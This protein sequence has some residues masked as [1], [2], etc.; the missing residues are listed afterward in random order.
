MLSVTGCTYLIFRTYKKW[1]SNPV[2]VSFDENS[3]PVSTIPFPA[4]TICPSAMFKRNFFNLTKIKTNEVYT[5]EQTTIQNALYSVCPFIQ[6]IPS[7]KILNF[8]YE[9]KKLAIPFDE[10]FHECVWRGVKIK[11][12]EKFHEVRTDEG[13][14]YTFNML[15][16]KDLLEEIVDKSLKFPKNNKKSSNWT[17]QGGFSTNEADIY[18]ERA[19]GSGFQAGLRVI[20]V[21]LKADLDYN[22]KGPVQGFK[23][24]LHSPTDIP[25]FSKQFYRIPLRREVLLSVTPEV[26]KTADGLQYYST[27]T[28]QCYYKGEKVLK[29][30]K[31]YTQPNCELECLTNY[32]LNSCNCTKFAMPF[33]SSTEICGWKKQ[34]CYAEVEARWI[35]ETWNEYL[36][37]D[38]SLNDK[39]KCNCL[40]S[41]TSI[42]YSADVSQGDLYF[43]EFQ[44]YLKNRTSHFDQSNNAYGVGD[45]KTSVQI[46][47]KD[48]NFIALKRSELYGLTDFLSN[49]GGLLGLFM[50]R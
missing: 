20:L 12:S 38:Q 5:E 46:Y 30:F 49:C 44:E 40:P 32:T 27:S 23:L 22:C 37:E 43:S 35:I 16:H 39:K 14:C 50:V 34:K 6:P 11:C 26:I 10:V 47:F 36:Q 4:V 21:A 1:Q 28:R 13:I 8:D 31:V 25:R 24:S 2:I 19:L 42:E 33:E 3:T 48:N 15:D 17:L 45:Y 7:D 18:P 41:C 9:L 29:Y